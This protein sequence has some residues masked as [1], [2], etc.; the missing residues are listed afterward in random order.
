MLSFR[1]MFDPG[2]AEGMDAN[3]GFR[4]GA[5]SFV[6]RIAKGRLHAERGD[7]AG[8]DL[9][10][11]GAAPAIAAFVYGDVPL[12]A[13]EAEGALAVEGSREVAA[14]FAG[15]FELPPKAPVPAGG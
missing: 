11:T 4:V 12:A 7:P 9:V 1:T 5:E 15:L 10:L 8:A 14:A 6:A 3:I 13:L 2:K